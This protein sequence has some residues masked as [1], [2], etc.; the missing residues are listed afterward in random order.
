[1]T[2][3]DCSRIDKLNNIQPNKNVLYI[4]RRDQ[5]IYENHSIELA[6]NLSYQLKSQFFIGIEFAKLKM[7]EIQE[8]FIL[9]GLN[10]IYTDCKKYNLSIH[11]IDDLKTFIDDKNIGTIILDFCPLRESLKRQDEIKSLCK[12]ISL[13]RCDSH[14]IVPCKLLTQYK[15]TPKAVKH[16]LYQTWNHFLKDY[17]KLEPH[18][19][20]AKTEDKESPFRLHEYTDKKYKFKGGYLQGMKTLNTFFKDKFSSY[21]EIRNNPDLDG[22]SNLSS[23]LHT[24]QISPLEVILLTNSKFA[25]E[26]SSSYIT[27]VDE[28][29]IWRE[30]AEHFVYHEPEY[31]NIKGALP[32]ARETLLTHAKDNRPVIYSQEQLEN[33][34]TA[35]ELWNAAQN[36][37]TS[38]GKI[39]GYVRMYWAKMLLKWF[40]DPNEALAFG[41]YLND[42]YSIDG[43]D[44]NGYLGVMWSICASMDRAFA[45]R[46][47]FG[48]IR[49]MKSIKCPS[50][51]KKWS[52]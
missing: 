28:C 23:Y 13:L 44:P 18:K 34:K 36:E 24:G 8:N 50:Y 7:N 37:L 11:D 22:L 21:S 41:I 6:Y 5:R 47:I 1:M 16:D 42:K 32:W 38:S 27:F 40:K 4:M 43:N 29:F 51:I 49:Y 25:S 19:Y 14:N 9:E 12:D 31:D 35:D 2:L 10:E 17:K 15:R 39:H 3:E 33:A 52:K 46:D 48:K 45:E 26:G 20:N 30:I